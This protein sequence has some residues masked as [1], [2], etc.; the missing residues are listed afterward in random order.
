MILGGS[1]MQRLRR[2]R[3]RRLRN[4]ALLVLL[5]GITIFLSLPPA[6]TG[7]GNVVVLTMV[8]GSEKRGWIQRVAPLFQSWWKE[9]H[10]DRSLEIH[11]IALGS[12][13]SM[14]QIILGEIKPTVWSPAS[15]VWIPLANYMWKQEY[16]GERPLVESWKPLVASPVVIATWR[17][18]AAQHN[19]TSWDSVHRIAVSPNSDLK[20]AHTDPQL[21]NSGFMA[22]LMEVSAAAG[23]F[24]QNLTYGDLLR[25]DVRQWLR[26]VEGK[27]V[28]Y[29][30]ST[31]FLADQAT[32]SGPSSLNV[33]VVYE[34]LVIEKNKQGEPKA[35][36]GQNLV[37]IYPSEGVLMSDH[38]FCVLNAPWVSEDQRKAAEEFC[39]FLTL[40]EIQRIAMEHGF[41]PVNPDVRLDPNIFNQEN[42]VSDVIPCPILE[43]PLDGMVL[44]RITDLWIISRPGE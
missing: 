33:L 25:S 38:A 2:K 36:W 9:Q 24:T 29:G 28:M 37:A 41:R 17:Q 11:F 7:E 19:I 23:C 34:N 32:T 44:Q 16:G 15:S 13:E 8:Y 1:E 40:P 43:S 3:L 20:F 12:R 39:S 5:I 27:A 26:D 21:S 4:I 35:R 22:L 6:P 18:Y 30:E 42:G 14:N 10:P 31:G